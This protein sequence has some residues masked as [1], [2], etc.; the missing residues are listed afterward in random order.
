MA[1]LLFKF[2][3]SL[4]YYGLEGFYQLAGGTNLYT[5]DC[6]KKAGLFK[7][8]TLPGNFVFLRSLFN[9]YLAEYL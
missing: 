1:I 4:L 7:A 6:L 5:V 9:S 8:R 3:K 2:S